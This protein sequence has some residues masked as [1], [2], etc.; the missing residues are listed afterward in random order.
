M[1]KCTTART[2]LVPCWLRRPRVFGLQKAARTA[3][4]ELSAACGHN[5]SAVIFRE[6]Y[7]LRYWISGFVALITDASRRVRTSARG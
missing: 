5:V 3:S 1:A 4:C 2:R 6:R 7:V